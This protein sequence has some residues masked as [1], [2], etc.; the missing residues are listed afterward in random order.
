MLGTPMPFPRVPCQIWLPTFGER[1]PYGNEQVT[2]A[3]D[4][5]IVMECCYAP[6]YATPDT[7]DRIEDGRPHEDEARVMF[8]LPKTLDADLRG[9]LIRALPPNDASMASHR[10]SVVGD[11]H[12]FMREATPGDMSWCVVGVRFDG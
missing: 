3:E 6:G 1:D 8:Y 5:D 10:F 2:Y 7:R 9:A 4:P 12:S 11:P